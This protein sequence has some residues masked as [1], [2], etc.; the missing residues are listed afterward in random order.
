MEEDGKEFVDG[1]DDGMEDF[2]YG[3]EENVGIENGKRSS[4]PSNTE[5]SGSPDWPTL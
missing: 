5:R 4:I 3:M 1:K 2:Y